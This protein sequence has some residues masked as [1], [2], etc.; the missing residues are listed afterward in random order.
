[1]DNKYKWRN[2]VLGIDNKSIVKSV[3]AYND[4]QK[5][6][7]FCGQQLGRQ[8]K[9]GMACKLLQIMTTNLEVIFKT[10]K[11]TGIN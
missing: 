2:H 5:K 1:V 6:F 10:M 11:G 8:K 7:R 4:A 3:N 9:P